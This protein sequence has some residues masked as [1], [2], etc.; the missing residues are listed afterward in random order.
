VFFVVFDSFFSLHFLFP[1]ATD[2]VRPSFMAEAAQAARGAGNWRAVSVCL[3]PKRFPD[4]SLRDEGFEISTP[5]PLPVL[6]RT[7][8]AF[9]PAGQAPARPG[10]AGQ[11]VIMFVAAFRRSQRIQRCLQP[12][13]NFRMMSGFWTSQVQNPDIK[14]SSAALG[15]SSRTAANHF[16]VVA[17]VQ[18]PQRT[19]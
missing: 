17:K 14:R 5:F 3:Q 18:T 12:F 6:Q 8:I 16:K 10:R 1:K 2:V 9:L 13:A 7:V 11:Y 19:L 4:I 15:E